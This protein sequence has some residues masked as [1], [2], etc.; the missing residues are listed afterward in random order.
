VPG[1]PARR[2]AEEF[3]MRK[4]VLGA[5]AALTIV[6]SASAI[7]LYSNSGSFSDPL[8]ITHPGGGFGGGDVTALQVTLGLNVFGFN[9]GGT[10]VVGDDFTVPAGETW[11]INEVQLYGYTTGALAPTINS[12]DYMFTS[13]SLNGMG[14]PATTNVAVAPGWAGGPLGV[15]KTTD[16][17]LT[18]NQRRVQ[19]FAVPVAPAYVANA[20]QHSLAWYYV[21]G[22]WCPPVV[23]KGA[24]N[25]PG[26]NGMQLGT[27]G[28]FAPIID[29][30]T[31]QAPQ[32]LPFIL[33]GT[34]TGGGCKWDLDGDGKVCQSDLG[35][36]LALYGTTYTQGDLGELLAQ[37]NGGCGAPCAP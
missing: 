34:K 10:F 4:F 35:L 5:V 1:S 33:R 37:Y 24:T 32:E 15:F 7:D 21:A 29:N 27:T 13:G 19:S 11:T 31:A 9:A 14:F 17:T 2:F 23:V 16:T 20:G 22:P 12:V 26:A 30:G 18:N 8:G 36:L 25:P 3:F 6:S 28:L